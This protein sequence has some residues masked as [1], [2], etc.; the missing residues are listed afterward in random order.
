[1]KRCLLMGKNKVIK[2]KQSRSFFFDPSIQLTKITVGHLQMSA[3]E[4]REQPG[5]QSPHRANPFATWPS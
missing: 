2:K 3:V 4:A 5:H 1:M